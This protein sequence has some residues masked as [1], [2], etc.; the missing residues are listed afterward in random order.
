[1]KIKN[2]C[3]TLISVETRCLTD[4]KDY[5]QADVAIDIEPKGTDYF[6]KANK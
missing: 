1:M 3:L 2:G 4:R 6:I 5:S